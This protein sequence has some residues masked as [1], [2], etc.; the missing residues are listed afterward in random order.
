[1]V[2]SKMARP[3]MSLGAMG[4]GESPHINI[5]PPR[6]VVTPLYTVSY[7]GGKAMLK[8][9][10]K[11]FVGGGA[12]SWETRYKNAQRFVD[13]EIL[14]L[15]EPYVPLLTGVLVFTGITGTDVGSGV[16]SWTAPYAKYQYY[17]KVMSY[18]P[19][20]PERV[21]VVTKKKLTYHGGGI[22]GSF[23]F[24]RM[25]EVS[26]KK[27]IADAKLIAGGSK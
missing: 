27:I 1:L 20:A 22:R 15:C 5:I 8:W 26:G 2:Q 24:E 4:K 16:V 23:W 18:D 9:N 14:H 13:S 3:N 10:T 19:F 11:K 6:D 17:G 7:A 21:K 25:K 12:T